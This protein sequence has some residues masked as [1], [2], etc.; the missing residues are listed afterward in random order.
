MKTN[1][2]FGTISVIIFI[3]TSCNIENDMKTRYYSDLDIYNL[4]GINEISNKNLKFPYIEIYSP[5]SNKKEICFFYDKETNDKRTY[6]KIDSIWVNEYSF[7][8][9]GTPSIFL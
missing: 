2:F 3:Y 7:N 1:I 5:N 9:C 8:D 6:T 4:E